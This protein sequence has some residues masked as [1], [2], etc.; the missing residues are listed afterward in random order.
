MM[1][2]WSTLWANIDWRWQ[3]DYLLMAL[4][5]LAWMVIIWPSVELKLVMQAASLRQRLWLTTLAI[6]G[7]WLMD[8][9]I[10]PS[11]HLHF[12][13]L[14][15]CMLMFGWRLATVALLLPSM[16]FSLLV[17]EQPWQFFA[18][19]LIAISLPLFV[20]YVVYHRC[21]HLLPHHVF[22]YIFCGGFLNAAVTLLVHLL[23]W[24]G[25]VYMTTEVSGEYLWDN[26]LT[27]APLLMFPE[28]L[29]NGMLITLLVVYRPQW[30]YDYSDR[31]YLWRR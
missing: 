2:Y 13:G 22:V 21:F 11:L 4:I 15:L 19:S 29:L 10:H 17:L 14:T 12:L 30:L 18:Y 20:S 3:N 1:Q 26:Y 23:L 8:A 28:A 9:S 24:A 27:I 25:F 6:F 31:I 16:A 7:L 5:W